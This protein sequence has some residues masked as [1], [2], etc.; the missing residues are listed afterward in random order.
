MTIDN[1]DTTEFEFERGYV[2]FP[3]DWFG[4]MAKIRLSH[5]QYEI[6]YAIITYTWG[7]FPYRTEAVIKTDDFLRETNMKHKSSVSRAVK[8]LLEK[9]MI[10]RQGEP[11]HPIYS[12][13]TD[14]E[15]WVRTPRRK[16]FTVGKY[17][18]QVLEEA[19]N[20]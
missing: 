16:R 10:I 18:S 4:A 5:S 14:Y 2:Y 1:N 9:N 13:Q 20:E 8:G 6:L 12:V 15:K 11:R 17:V 3:R 7:S 19:G